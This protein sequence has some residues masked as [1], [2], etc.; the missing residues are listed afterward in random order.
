MQSF[1]GPDTA[2]LRYQ[3]LDAQGVRVFVEEERSRDQDMAH[4]NEKIGYMA[5]WIGA[6]TVPAAPEV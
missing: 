3:N 6:F 2:T 1:N 4:A 5:L